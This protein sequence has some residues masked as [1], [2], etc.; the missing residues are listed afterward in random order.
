MEHA[1]VRMKLKIKA[2]KWIGKGGIILSKCKSGELFT[3][4]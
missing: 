1:P 2:E 3:D 4:K